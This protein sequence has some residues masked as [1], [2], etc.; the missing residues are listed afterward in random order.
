[1]NKEGTTIELCITFITNVTETIRKTLYKV[2][3][4][5]YRQIYLSVASSL[6]KNLLWFICVVFVNVTKQK[7]ALIL[8][9]KIKN[10][11]SW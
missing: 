11:A 7:F 5:S 3:S 2:C 9:I 4:T 1:M 10:V 6:H 8:K